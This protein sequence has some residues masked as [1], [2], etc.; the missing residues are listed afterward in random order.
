[1]AI[2]NVTTRPSPV[3]ATR[4]R[5]NERRQAL[6]AGLWCILFAVPR[7]DRGELDA[8][9]RTPGAGLRDKSED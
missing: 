2:R 8:R 1:M 9:T 3:R 6:I 7:S 4:W 5:T